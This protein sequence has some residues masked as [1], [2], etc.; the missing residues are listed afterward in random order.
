MRLIHGPDWL[1]QEH[2]KPPRRQSARMEHT[3]IAATRWVAQRPE[4]SKRVS[5]QS[6]IGPIKGLFM[7]LE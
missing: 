4:G 5:Q 3:D 6:Q 7:R 2:Q 1:L